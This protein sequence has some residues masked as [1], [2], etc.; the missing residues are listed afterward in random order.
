MRTSQRVLINTIAQYTRTIINMV[1]SLF[2]VRLVLGALG[3]SD[4]GLYEAIGSFVNYLSVLD[5]GFGAVVT[6]YTAKYQQ[7]GSIEA[8]DKFLYTCR[9]IYVLLSFV[10][11]IIFSLGVKHSNLA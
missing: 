9:N 3:Q 8:R 5:L 7:E 11:L 1:L 2:T 6:R 4:Y 10:I